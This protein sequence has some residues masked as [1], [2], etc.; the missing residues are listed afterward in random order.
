VTTH[1]QDMLPRFYLTRKG[2][3][4][5]RWRGALA[6][7]TARDPSPYHDPLVARV[8]RMADND[9]AVYLAGEFDA[10]FASVAAQNRELVLERQPLG[11]GGVLA[12]VPGCC[13]ETEALLRRQFAWRGALAFAKGIDRSPSHDRTTALRLKRL[14]NEIVVPLLRAW[15]AGWDDAYDR[16]DEIAL[17]RRSIL[18]VPRVIHARH[19]RRA[20]RTITKD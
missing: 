9:S 14:P 13:A 20:P 18:E 4:F 7:L 11:S 17:E 5:V 1:E 10:G 3:L 15:E 2:A 12:P 19:I 8:L 6:S 16:A